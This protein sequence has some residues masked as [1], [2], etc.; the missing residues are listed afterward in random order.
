MLRW[1]YDQISGRAPERP[2]NGLSFGIEPSGW[3]RTIFPM[4]EARS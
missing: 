1:P 2:A 4:P 3:M